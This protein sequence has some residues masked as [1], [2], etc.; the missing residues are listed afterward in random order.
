MVQPYVTVVTIDGCDDRSDPICYRCKTCCSAI[1]SLLSA[2]VL[3]HRNFWSD[4]HASEIYKKNWNVNCLSWGGLLR[5]NNYQELCT[6][7][8]CN[9]LLFSFSCLMEWLPLRRMLPHASVIVHQYGLKGLYVCSEE[10]MSQLTC[11]RY[12]HVTVLKYV[13][14]IRLYSGL[15]S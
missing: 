11:K 7:Y 4:V 9:R 14:Y 5:L 10:D 1:I 12:R 3:H 2:A 15:L 8:L 13:H 6:G